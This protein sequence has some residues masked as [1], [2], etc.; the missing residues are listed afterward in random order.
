MRG[1]IATR[2][3][4]DTDMARRADNIT[5]GEVAAR[6]EQHQKDMAEKAEQIEKAVSDVETERGTLEALEVSGTSEAAEVVERAIQDAE[7]ASQ[8]EFDGHSSGLEH[9]HEV[10]AEHEHEFQERSDSTV[11]DVRKIETAGEKVHGEAARNELAEA[12]ESAQQDIEFLNEHLQ[13]LQDARNESDHLHQE[14]E[15]RIHSGGRS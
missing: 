11:S 3:S 15:A 13:R 10:S 12:K 9:T 7:K 4:G 8:Q 1:V 5:R 2:R 6:V 14:H